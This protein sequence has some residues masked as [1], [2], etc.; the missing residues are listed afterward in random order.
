MKKW[1]VLSVMLL[2]LCCSVSAI[3]VD[4]PAFSVRVV[5]TLDTENQF[6]GRDTLV[7][8]W[9][10]MANREDLTL[11][12]IHGLCLAYDN[13]VLQLIKWDCTDG[14]NDNLISKNFKPVLT[15]QDDGIYAGVY[16]RGA[17]A[18][19]AVN[20]D[21]S[22]GYLHLALGEN[23]TRY[24]CSNGQYETL[25]KA[26]FAFR[27]GK[28]SLDLYANSI[29]LMTVSELLATSQSQALLLSTT[30]ENIS[31][32][33]YLSHIYG[34]AT[35]KDNLN[36][37]D[38]IYP[39]S[40]RTRKITN[41]T[42][43]NNKIDTDNTAKQTN[44][45]TTNTVP[46]T[47]T[48]LTITDE[49]AMINAEP[50]STSDGIIATARA[51]AFLDVPSEAWFFDAVKFVTDKGLMN[52]TSTEVFSP[53]LPMTRAMFATV[54][55]RLAGT[56]TTAISNSFSDVPAEQWYSQAIN[57][58]SEKN[59]ITGYGGSLFGLNDNITREQ[60]VVILSRYEELSGNNISTR[61]NLDRFIDA[62]VVSSWAKEAMQWAVADGIITGR[63]PTELAPKGNITRAEIAQ[64]LVRQY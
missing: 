56:P 42:T 50:T 64:I 21:S 36:A 52:G 23:T 40:D 14:I 31:I 34:V 49:Q 55:H 32:Y 10:I 1:I 53:N 41:D 62:G 12:R 57:W 35:N 8:D 37:P 38:I 18:Y 43:T 51:L 28:S 16:G 15:V 24:S 39:G 30:E 47:T 5:G 3:A 33:S 54:L 2:L 29:R 44:E 60:V 26:R 46:S 59:L 63:S 11:T 4:D 20:N 61:D 17:Q 19:A 6:E 45:T 27:P 9:Q 22:I 13:T 48:T 58:A 25:E 7:L